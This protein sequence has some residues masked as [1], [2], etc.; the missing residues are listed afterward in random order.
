[1]VVAEHADGGAIGEVGLDAG[2]ARVVGVA[3]ID[4]GMVV[5]IFVLG[6]EHLG[7]GAGEWE[8]EVGRRTGMGGGERGREEEGERRGNV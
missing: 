1:V 6:A 4:A 3:A 2:V 5:H 8:K 7:G